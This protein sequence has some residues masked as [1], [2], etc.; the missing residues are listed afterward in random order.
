M[1]TVVNDRADDTALRDLNAL[2]ALIVRNIGD[3]EAAI[4]RAMQELDKRLWKEMAAVVEVAAGR[5]G[6]RSDNKPEDNEVQFSF[7][8]AEWQKG[9]RTAQFRFSIEEIPGATNDFPSSWIAEAVAENPQGARLGLVLIQDVL[10]PRALARVIKKKAELLAKLADHKIL[11]NE[12]NALF[13]EINIDKE[14]L[15]Q[16]FEEDDFEIALNPL[17]TAMKTI[18][19]A[20]QLINQ[21]VTAIC[22]EDA[23]T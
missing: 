5:Y 16:A 19:Q 21:I 8:S 14:V 10:K 11:L 12:D 18:D 3:I 17:L 13:I 23:N 4:E 7:E 22:T 20:K 1:P 15:A 6:W 9:D 2:N